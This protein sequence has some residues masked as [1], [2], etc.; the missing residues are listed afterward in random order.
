M[1]ADIVS[2]AALAGVTV[3]DNSKLTAVANAKKERTLN[4]R[5]IVLSI[6]R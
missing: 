2:V 5:L 1:L 6:G 3:D 4:A